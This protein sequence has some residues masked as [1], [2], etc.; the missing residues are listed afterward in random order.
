M[1]STANKRPIVCLLSVPHQYS[2]DL[3]QVFPRRLPSSGFVS[4]L[5]RLEDAQVTGVGLFAPPRRLKP[6][7]AAL[8]QKVHQHV[9]D[10]QRH[11]VACGEGNSV[12]KLGVFLDR[13][14][15]SPNSIAL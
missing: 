6:L 4:A 11:A 8:A 15:A 9:D 2:F 7:G 14:L 3:A 13:V 10:L 5:D 1:I 12:V